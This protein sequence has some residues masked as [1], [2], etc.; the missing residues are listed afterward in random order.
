M[1]QLRILFVKLPYAKPAYL[2]AG[3]QVEEHSTQNSRS[4]PQK[5]VFSYASAIPITAPG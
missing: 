5:T 1:L 4:H 3:F 2:H